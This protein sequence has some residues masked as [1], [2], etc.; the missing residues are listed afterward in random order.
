MIQTTR[1]T[2]HLSKLHQSIDI[3]W[4]PE[5]PTCWALAPTWLHVTSAADASPASSAGLG[6]S[7]DRVSGPGSM[8]DDM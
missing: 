6:R 3:G 7:D 5:Y 8:K 4:A 1:T 2:N